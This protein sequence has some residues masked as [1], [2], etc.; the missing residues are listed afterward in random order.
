MNI[1]KKKKKIMLSIMY[2]NLYVIAFYFFVTKLS[3]FHC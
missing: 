3:N 1:Y 2:Y